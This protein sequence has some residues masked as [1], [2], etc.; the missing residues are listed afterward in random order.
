MYERIIM[1]RIAFI[2]IPVFVLLLGATAQDVAAKKPL[3]PLKISIQPIRT[4]ISPSTIRPGEILEFKITAV[5]SMAADSMTIDVKLSGGTRIVAGESFWRGPAAKNEEKVLYL[6]VQAPEKGKG[7]IKASASVSSSGINFSA[8]TQYE[9]GAREKTKPER[10]GVK[11]KDH[12]G[13]PI[14]EY[15]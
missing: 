3:P 1:R 7:V 14:I 2:L 5:S 8:E 9:L 10:E 13:R 4:D 6:T 15:R 12:K 11:K